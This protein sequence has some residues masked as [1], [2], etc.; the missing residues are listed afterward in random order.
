MV[1]PA[2]NGNREPWPLLLTTPRRS[3]SSSATG[4]PDNNQLRTDDLPAPLKRSGSPSR[5]CRQHFFSAPTWRSTKRDSIATE[6]ASCTRAPTI[7]S[8]DAQAQD[9]AMQQMLKLVA[10]PE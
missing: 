5:S 3:R 7:R 1:H 4:G 8:P 2:G 10:A 6:Y 9:A